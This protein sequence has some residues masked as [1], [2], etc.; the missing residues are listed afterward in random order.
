M[1]VLGDVGRKFRRTILGRRTLL[2]LWV[3]STVQCFSSANGWMTKEATTSKYDTR[4][5]PSFLVAGRQF[6]SSSKRQLA[7]KTKIKM[8]IGDACGLEYERKFTGNNILANVQLSSFLE[9]PLTYPLHPP[10]I[11]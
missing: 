8:S 4:F 6:S 5:K 11:V 1:A 2:L 3:V 7:Y 9:R 10:K